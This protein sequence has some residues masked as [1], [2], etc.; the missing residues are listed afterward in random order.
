[1]WTDVYMPSFRP[2]F[3]LAKAPQV[4]FSPL[5]SNQYT[6]VMTLKSIFLTMLVP[7]FL[8][9]CSALSAPRFYDQS[10]DVT[11]DSPCYSYAD[12][13]HNLGHDCL[14]S[15]GASTSN[16]PATGTN[17]GTNF[18]PCPD[19]I[20]PPAPTSA[21][22][23]AEED[24]RVAA[25]PATLVSGNIAESATTT[26]LPCYNYA[27]PD[28]G[29]GD[30]CICSNSAGSYISTP[31]AQ[32]TGT[33]TGSNYN[34]CPYTVA[35]TIQPSFVSTPSSPP[36]VA[37]SSLPTTATTLL[38]DTAIGTEEPTATTPTDS[39]TAKI[40]TNELTATPTTF[41]STTP[42]WTDEPFTV[43]A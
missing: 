22:R 35:P 16:A 21:P 42:V 26:Y 3:S 39:S 28:E 41:S 5:L 18:N 14:C 4:I 38:T 29:I 23:S 27:D 36:G 15:N 17:T 2:A 30:Y 1:M 7:L 13:D 19:T 40:C 11:P 33:N 20:A 6:N 32:A 34:P 8:S 24:A 12:P 43:L 9:S 10:S 25:K 31:I 37:A